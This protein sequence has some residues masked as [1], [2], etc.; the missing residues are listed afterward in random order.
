[1]SVNFDINIHK[2]KNGMEI[3][4]I[5]GL[6]IHSKYDPLKEA[7]LIIEKNFIPGIN[8]VLFG[9]GQG[10]IFNELLNKIKGTDSKIIVIDP[11]FEVK[12]LKGIN[13]VGLPMEEFTENFLLLYFGTTKEVKSIISPNYEKLCPEETKKVL[14]CIKNYIMFK[15]LSNNTVRKDAMLWNRNFIHN[16]GYLPEDRSLSILKN[17][18]NL[19]VVIASG[20]PS[21][22]KQLNLLKEN[23]EKCIVI[24]AGSTINALVAEEIEPDFLISIDGKEIN[25]HH[26]KHLNLKHSILIYSLQNLA[27]IR[28]HYNK[29]ALYFL[30]SDMS[31]QKVQLERIMNT[32]IPIIEGGG[33]VANFALTIAR[34]ISTGP[35]ALIGQDLAYTNNQTHA[36]NHKW[37]KV[38]DENFIKEKS[39]FY[40]DGYY[41]NEKV[42]TTPPFFSMKKRFEELLEFLPNTDTIFNCTEGGVNIDKMKK[43]SFKDF[44]KS[45]MK[46]DK[47]KIDIIGSEGKPKKYKNVLGKLKGDLKELYRLRKLLTD[48]LLCLKLNKN[49]ASY[50]ESI[51]KKLSHNDLIIEQISKSTVISPGMDLVNLEVLTKFRPK[52][53]ETEIEKFK[54][55]DEQSKF[56][57]KLMLDLVD[58]IILEVKITV[59]KIEGK[60]ND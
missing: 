26:Y 15:T 30:S 8:Y 29:S 38:I 10:Y 33:S 22:Q 21:L 4:N 47:S 32:E 50:P 57:Y 20:G 6:Y 53:G 5:N 42:L 56:L 13:F 18:F 3:A 14:H 54:R 40:T 48:N 16:L 36:K 28:E 58:K 59:K 35:I 45:Y 12:T 11:I 24:A 9:Y 23:R 1:M 37:F 17:R 34:Y 52:K 41:E 46:E 51:I 60:L 31:G 25:I 7:N 44:I 27:A 43:I 55:I 19:P 49:P 2:S 39:A